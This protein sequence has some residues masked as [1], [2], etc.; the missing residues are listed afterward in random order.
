[1]RKGVRAVSHKKHDVQID[2][3]LRNMEIMKDVL[4]RVSDPAHEDYGNHWTAEQEL[5]TTREATRFVSIWKHVE[6]A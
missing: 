5:P 3:K 4:M 2:I 1:V 6:L